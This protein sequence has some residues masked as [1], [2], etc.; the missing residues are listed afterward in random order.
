MG[1]MLV[2]DA[3]KEVCDEKKQNPGKNLA[4]VKGVIGMSCSVL[5]VEG[6]S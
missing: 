1:G 3:A 6:C 2:A 5:L 4:D